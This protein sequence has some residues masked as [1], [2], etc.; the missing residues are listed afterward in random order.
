[1]V[2]VVVGCQRFVVTSKDKNR[3]LWGGIWKMETKLAM[4]LVFKEDFKRIMVDV[5]EMTYEAVKAMAKKFFAVDKAFHFH[6]KDE[7]GRIDITSQAE[8][9][10]A[11][12]F[13]CIHQNTLTLVVEQNVEP[14]PKIPCCPTPLRTLNH[15]DKLEECCKGFQVCGKFPSYC[16]FAVHA[17]CCRGCFLNNKSKE[18]IRG[19]RYK[20]TYCN[21]FDLC[22]A[23]FEKERELPGSI[24]DKSHSEHFVAIAHPGSKVVGCTRK[25][26]WSQNRGASVP[27]TDTSK[28]QPDTQ[29]P[30]I[31]RMEDS[32][33]QEK[34]KKIEETLKSQGNSILKDVETPNSLRSLV[35]F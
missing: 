17:V 5:N 33:L 15:L 7:K 18:S 29:E 32:I 14:N 26:R 28:D 11:V 6:Y 1:L 16:N 21:N 10:E 9:S 31:L 24:H 25:R 35:A 4:K 12:R 19:T 2:G 20:C 30:S 27:T 34:F 8:L 13:T 23:C 3:I 22:K